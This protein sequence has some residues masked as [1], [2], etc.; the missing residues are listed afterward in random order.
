[1]LLAYLFPW[2]FTV[3]NVIIW[4]FIR[5]INKWTAFTFFVLF[6][7]RFNLFFILRKCLI[8]YYK[9][10][11]DRFRFRRRS[12]RFRSLK[13]F[14]FTTE[15]NFHQVIKSSCM[16]VTIINDVSSCL[17]RV[18]IVQLLHIFYNLLIWFDYIFTNNNSF[19]IISITC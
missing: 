6:F 8:F 14:S 12:N 9:I 18:N 1:M 10:I 11:F 15:F 3:R 2:F 13:K 16:I 17:N 19:C 4:L 5:S 7:W